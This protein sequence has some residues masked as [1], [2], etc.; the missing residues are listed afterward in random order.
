MKRFVNARL[1]L[2]LVF[3]LI[4]GILLGYLF[5]RIHINLLYVIAFVP[6]VSVIFIFCFIYSRKKLLIFSILAAVFFFIG[7][8]YSYVKLDGYDTKE[9]INGDTYTI[10]ATVC[11]KGKYDNGEYIVIKNAKANGQKIKGKIKV[12]LSSSYG[13]YCAVGYKVNFTASVTAYDTFPYGKLNYNALKN[14]KYRCNVRG[15]LTAT[16]GF[17]LFGS[18]NTAIRNKLYNN[19]DYD[20][21]SVAYA[22]LTG[23][24]D[25]IE[26][27]SMTTFRY[28]GVAHIFA[29][30]GLHIGI[31]YGL[32]R[33]LCKKLHINKYIGLVVCIL[34][35]FLYSGV[36][37]FTL[38]SIR[39]LIMCTVSATSR[40]SFAKYDSL[41]SLSLSVIVILLCDPLNLFNVGFQLSICAVGGIILL[42]KNIVRPFRK[43][44][45]NIKNGIGVSLSAQAGTLPV[46][47][48]RFG[49]ISGAGILLNILIVPVLSAIFSIIFVVTLLSL[50]LPFIA[51]YVIPYAVLPLELTISLLT[52]A[53][54]EKALISGFGA[55]VFIPIY[56]FGLL[57][58]SDKFNLKLKYRLSAII[59]AVAVLCTYV[60]LKSFSPFNGH[61]IIVSAYYGGGEILIKSKNSNILI[62]TENLYLSQ[63]NSFLN[64]YYSSNLNALII[65][66]GENCAYLYGNT[67][68]NCDA[69]IYGG[70]I[71]IQPFENK[72]IKYQNSFTL[73]GVNFEFWDGYSLLAKCDGTTVGI[74]AG[75]NIPFGYCDI[76]LTDSTDECE[77]KTVISFNE[78]NF[79]NCI[80][81]KGNFIFKLKSNGGQ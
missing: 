48:T 1:P 11:E 10:N 26:D 7:T 15:G 70:Y 45:P 17:S 72:T 60:P 71:N 12:Y 77:A 41:N 31:I 33:L 67:D 76:L 62:I 13:D 47:L 57:A 28:G 35:I 50:I 9:L 19:L 54:F 27:G 29:I 2:I 32:L 21:A 65:L 66:G 74:C 8:I 14:I 58:L 42:A 51:P 63:I 37:G 55:G 38:S 4:V 46:M 3:A 39:A 24:T 75:N 68:F 5:I 73:N 64:E 23:N 53:G 69:Y 43:A 30:S 59:C 44:P 78:R 25:G 52:N 79:N 22:M 34:P 40:I 6:A 36:C 61:K 56:Y 20:T 18:V 80:Y 81:D 49:Y 16:Y